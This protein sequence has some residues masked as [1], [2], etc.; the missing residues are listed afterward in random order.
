MKSK[1]Y[2]WIVR[3]LGP[4]VRFIFRLHY[5]GVENE[6]DASQGPYVMICNHISNT[7]PVFLCASGTKQQPHF[8]A[9]KE[10]FKV[11]LL[12]KLVAALGA[13]PVDR[14]GADVSAI[15]NSVKMLGEGKSIGIFP[16]G[17]RQKGITPM[18]AT[19]KNGAALIA[20]RIGAP[21]VP[22]YIWRKGK[23]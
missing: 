22:V 14:G 18:E 2:I 11:P 13:Y 6:P 8:M 1:F 19:L 23:R 21:I 15:R 20:S 12:N 17:H 3:I 5:H 7:D 4:A 10:L 16:Q 9:K